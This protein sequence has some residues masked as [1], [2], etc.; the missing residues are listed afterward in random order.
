[1]TRRPTFAIACKEPLHKPLT[2]DDVLA[3]ALMI[4][5]GRIFGPR[6][7]EVRLINLLLNKTGF[8][9]RPIIRSV[10]HAR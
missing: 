9:I 4:I 10:N 2:S 6:S 1:M 7:V 3:Q 5:R 8:E